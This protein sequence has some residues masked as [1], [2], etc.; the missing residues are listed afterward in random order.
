MRAR[1]LQTSTRA[2]ANY[3][4]AAGRRVLSRAVRLYI[5]NGASRL[6][7]KPRAKFPDDLNQAAQADGAL[8]SSRVFAA[9]LRPMSP[10]APV[11]HARSGDATPLRSAA[12]SPKSHAASAGLSRQTRRCPPARQTPARAKRYS[13]ATNAINQARAHSARAFLYATSRNCMKHSCEHSSAGS[14]PSD[15]AA[16]ILQCNR[17]AANFNIY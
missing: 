7:T 1:T 4:N 11:R 13:R 14:A 12:E 15:C 3:R 17:R 8:R 16:L 10:Q 5:A 2:P 9:A 6:N